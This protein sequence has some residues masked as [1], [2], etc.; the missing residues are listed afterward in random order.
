MLSTWC[1]GASGAQANPTQTE[2]IS[3]Q[4]NRMP[5]ASVPETT[6]TA[7][8]T[9]QRHI[10]S[11]AERLK[12]VRERRSADAAPEFSCCP[13]LA[14]S[15]LPCRLFPCFDDAVKADQVRPVVTRFDGHGHFVDRDDP[16]PSV[17]VAYRITFGERPDVARRCSVSKATDADAG[18]TAANR[19]SELDT[20]RFALEAATYEHEQAVSYGSERDIASSWADVC[21]AVDVVEAADAAY[22]AALALVPRV[23]ETA[24]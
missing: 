23:L 20:A 2:A 1:G 11:R 24:A 22:A 8:W 13:L 17:P 7:I 19:A 3:P 10:S 5:A 4:Y 18:I 12:P 15:C 6:A 16:V 9:S 21:V 14:P